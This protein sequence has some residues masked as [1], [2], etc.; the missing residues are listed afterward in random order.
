MHLSRYLKI[1]PWPDDPEY[2]LLYS[3]KN[4]A[5]ALVPAAD[6]QRLRAGEIPPEHAEML[7]ELGMLVPDLAQERAEVFDLLAEINHQDEGL[8]CSIILG[9]ACN[10][11]C[12]YCYEGSL[13]DGRAMDDATGAQLLAFLK[14]R[15]LGRGK[16]KMTL[17]FYGGEPLLYVERILAIARPL[18]AFVEE[19][20]GEFRFSLVT[21]GSLLTREVVAQ[22]KPAGL[23]AAK[24]TV[25]GPPAD[26][27]RLRPF[28]SGAPSFEA[29]MDNVRACRDL[30]KIGF[31]GN[32]TRDSFPRVGELLDIAIRSGLGPEQL[33]QV[34]FHPVIATTD[35]FAHP[36]FTGGCLTSEEPWL[37]EAAL[38]VR[39]EAVRRGF[40]SP[41]MIPSPCM[42]DLDDALVVNYDGALFKC[43]AMIGRPEFA[44]GDVWQGVGDIA[45]YRRGHWQQH[46]ECTE[47][48]YL[49][50]CFGGCRFFRKLKTGAIDGVDCRRVMLD[51][52][53]ERIVRQDL[54]LV[55]PRISKA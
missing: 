45:P 53:L 17:D 51:A 37:A 8:N 7:A 48:A 50:L 41:R 3:T 16:K 34:Q 44:V 22:L 33:G 2:L 1:Y 49:P 10:F 6:G 27:N 25:D 14:G 31:G 39:A 21:N 28:K 23:Y 19:R 52:S 18:Q 24:V 54:E 29:I 30:I 15:Y 43:V 26:H 5:M 38:A 20:G 12:Q 11:A 40:P 35:P 32:Y 42:V 9:L 4:A 55:H 13:K 36:E 46:G 47:C